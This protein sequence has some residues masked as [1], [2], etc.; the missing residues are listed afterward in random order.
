MLKVEWTENTPRK[1]QRFAGADFPSENPDLE[2]LLTSEL[3]ALT[4]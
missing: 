3:E 4:K 1:I 2:D